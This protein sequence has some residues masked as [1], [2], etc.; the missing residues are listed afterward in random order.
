MFNRC[1]EEASNWQKIELIGSS[2]DSE[3]DEVMSHISQ[4]AVI[5]IITGKTLMYKTKPPHQDKVPNIKCIRF[6]FLDFMPPPPPTFVTSA[7]PDNVHRCQLVGLGGAN[8]PRL[9]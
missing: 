7:N 8:S 9:I 1:S 3:S 2:V 6:V 4:T 5:R